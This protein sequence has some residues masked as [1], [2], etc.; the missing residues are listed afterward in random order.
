MKVSI[1]F[2]LRDVVHHE[3]EPTVD[4]ESHLRENGFV[5]RDGFSIS[6]GFKYFCF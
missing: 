1:T 6:G 2:C 5:D 4:A 3:Y